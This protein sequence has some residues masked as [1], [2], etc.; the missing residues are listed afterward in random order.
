MRKKLSIAEPSISAYSWQSTVL[1]ILQTDKRC[2]D[3]IYCNY[4]QTYSV[5]RLYYNCNQFAGE[6]SFYYNLYGSWSFYEYK[7]NPW[8]D[9]YKIPRALIATNY[10]S[11]IEF[12]IERINNLEYVYLPI[13][14]QYISA[15]GNGT[16]SHTMLI[17]GYDDELAEFYCADNFSHK[18]GFAT[19]PFVELKEA[20]DKFDI[21]TLNPEIRN[22]YTD[23]YDVCTLKMVEPIWNQEAFKFHLYKLIS[24]L[25]EYLLI[26]DYGLGY[27]P[28][29]HYVFGIECY[30]ALADYLNDALS[31]KSEYFD[32][33]AF[34]A[35]Y[36][37]KSLMEKR[38]I[39]L[40]SN[41]FVKDVTRYLSNYQSLIKDFDIL[42]RKVIKINLKKDHLERDIADLSCNLKIIKQKEAQ[43]LSALLDELEQ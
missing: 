20:F 42:I 16:G 22:N 26:G 39:Y 10:K 15:Y 6:L 36:D 3:W 9:Y 37:H 11:I 8:L 28:N 29:K 41:G 18:Y 27:R 43:V 14:M 24:D 35:F 34:S 4:V 12:I 19:V 23:I 40:G 21:A 31:N 38:I 13:E 25:K 30:D 7:A 2:D 5:R 32:Y 33:K 1:A 17:Y